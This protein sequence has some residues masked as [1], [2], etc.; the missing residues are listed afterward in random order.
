MEIFTTKNLT[1]IFVEEDKANFSISFEMLV[2]IKQIP[3]SA[4]ARDAGVLKGLEPPD[5][6]NSAPLKFLFL[7]NSF[8]FV[9]IS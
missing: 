9:I 4:G 3:S 6:A 2:L 8:F 1:I 7:S 5:R